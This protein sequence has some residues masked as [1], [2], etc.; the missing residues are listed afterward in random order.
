MLSADWPFTKH[1]IGSVNS[2]CHLLT[3]YFAFAEEIPRSLAI[4]SDPVQVLVLIYLPVNEAH[5]NNY[6]F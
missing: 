2:F 5:H 6:F 4:S 1:I 3:W